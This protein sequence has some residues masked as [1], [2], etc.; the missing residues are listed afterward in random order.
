[1]AAKGERVPLGTKELFDT[2]LRAVA[3]QDMETIEA[4]AAE[5]NMNDANF[6]ACVDDSGDTLLHAAVQ[7]STHVM[8][9]V[10]DKLAPAGAVVDAKNKLGKTAL[11]EAAKRNLVGC[12]KLLLESGA[13]P[14]VMNELGSTPFHTACACGSVETMDVLL[15]ACEGVTPELQD[16]SGAYPIHRCAYD[17]DERVFEM[18]VKH[19]AIVD[20]R[21]AQECTAV[22]LAVK[23]DRVS[24]VR[25]LLAV[26]GGQ[27][28]K[29][30]PSVGDK[31]GNTVLH[32]A[33]ARCL[34]GM[35]VM[36]VK[37]GGVDIN[38]A[39]EDGYTPLHIA[40]Q[41]FKGDSQE[42]E[43]LVLDLLRM[44]A[45]PS[46]ANSTNGRKPVDYVL[47]HH[48]HLFDPAEFQKRDDRAAKK[49]DGADAEQAKVDEEKRKYKEDIRKQHKE[50]ERVRREVVEQRRKEAEER[51]REEEARL[52][53]EEEERAKELEEAEAK[54]KKG[55]G[56]KAG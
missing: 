30:D 47:R 51:Q 31:S 33:V 10:L 24:F 17:G 16:G 34:H 7:P 28:E 36:L 54:K 40:A 15:A 5:F 48:A 1:M 52:R 35:V 44:G 41:S 29:L 39:N 14:L 55:K 23:M 38:K 18:L 4:H 2:L 12:V 56:K 9:Y 27:E 45:D 19:G 49:R 3:E 20:M 11:H 26:G 37:E 32:Y 6:A 50:R 43:D 8:T 42:W 13:D 21:D 22:H 46:V 25:K 53:K